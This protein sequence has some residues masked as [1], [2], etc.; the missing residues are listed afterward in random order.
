[1]PSRLIPNDHDGSVGSGTATSR[2]VVTA[3]KY[4]AGL[5]A[6]VFWV[7]PLRT[8]IQ[9]L[10]FVASVAVMLTCHFALSRIDEEYANKN[11]GYWPEPLDWTS[12]PS[13]S[14]GIDSKQ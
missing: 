6:V 10:V 1:V 12:P 2:V 11:A 5:S 4:L 3:V 8:S 7:C 13:K 9:V 14:E